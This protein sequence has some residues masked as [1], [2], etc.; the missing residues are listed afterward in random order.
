M[1]SENHNSNLR[2]IKFILSLIIALGVHYD[3]KGQMVTYSGPVEYHLEIIKTASGGGTDGGYNWNVS[4]DERQIIEGNFYVTFTGNARLGL[5]HSEKAGDKQSF[6]G[7]EI[8][9]ITG[10]KLTDITE[11][12]QY[13][14]S[15]NN[16]GNEQKTSQPCYDDRLVFKHN[17]TPGDSRTERFGVNSTRTDPAKTVIEGGNIMFRDNKYILML[18]GKM[19]VSMTSQ[20]Y[21]SLTLPC[22]DT[23]IPPKSISKTTVLDFPIVIHGEK[24][25]DNPDLLEGTFVQKEETGDDCRTCLGGMAR[26]VHGDMNCS[27]VTKI[28]TSWTLVKRTKECDATISYLREDVKINGVAAK[29]GTIKVGAGDVIETGNIGSRIQIHLPGNETFSLGSKTRLVLSNPCNPAT[30]KP[31]SKGQ[32]VKGKIMSVIA[33]DKSDFKQNMRTTA[34]GVRGQINNTLPIFYVSADPD[35]MPVPLHQNG[36]LLFTLP[37]QQDDPEKAELIE[38]YQSLP[39]NQTAYYLDFE[40]GIVRDLTVLK[41]TVRVKDDMGLR[42]MDITEGT[43]INHWSDGTP[44]TAIVIFAK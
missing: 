23:L 13:V 8:F 24:I 1:N 5:Y 14:N 22:L 6:N 28:T 20:N 7:R 43:T 19:K 16:E 9:G 3:L 10:L 29:E 18:M 36:P 25:F 15:V 41:G 37:N 44:M 17:A 35:F 2:Y 11:N 12:I 4:V 32:L 34:S 42:T 38:G 27:Y 40:D 21:S 39:D 31:Q 30:M 33:G 26:M